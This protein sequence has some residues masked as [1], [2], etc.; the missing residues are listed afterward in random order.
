MS[1]IDDE[2]D[3]NVFSGNQPNQT[4]ARIEE[5]HQD[6]EYQPENQM[7]EEYMQPMGKK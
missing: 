4:G 1:F 6:L 7:D 5:N 2:E 3:F